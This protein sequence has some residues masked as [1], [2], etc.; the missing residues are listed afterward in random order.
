MKENW[1]KGNGEYSAKYNT[2]MGKLADQNSRLPTGAKKLPVSSFPLLS[3]SE[4]R[5]P[6]VTLLLPFSV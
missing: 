6:L 5:F 3:T 2:N 4:L 1:H